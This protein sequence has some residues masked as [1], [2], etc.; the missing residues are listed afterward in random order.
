MRC[1]RPQAPSPLTSRAAQWGNAFPQTPWMDV[2]SQTLLTGVP[3]H[4]YLTETVTFIQMT[5]RPSVGHRMINRWHSTRYHLQASV[6][7]GGYVGSED[8]GE[9]LNRHGETLNRHGETGNGPDADDDHFSTI[10][11]LDS[12]IMIFFHRKEKRWFDSK[13]PL[14]Q[15]QNLPSTCWKWRFR[16]DIK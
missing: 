3:P 7:M 13:Q 4:A 12:G 11:H 9:T 1:R 16:R 2:P 8:F 15:L 10:V 5:V 6:S 14:L